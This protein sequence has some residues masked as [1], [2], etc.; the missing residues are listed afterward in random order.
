MNIQELKDKAVNVFKQYKYNEFLLNFYLFIRDDSYVDQKN[1][2]NSFRK[3]V[4]WSERAKTTE[5]FT[6][7]GTIYQDEFVNGILDGKLFKYI[8]HVDTDTW[9]FYIV[10]FMGDDLVINAQFNRK[11]DCDWND[12]DAYEFSSLEEFHDSLDLE[13]FLSDLNSNV[14]RVRREMINEFKAREKHL[15]EIKYEKKFT[16]R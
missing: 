12:I 9:K 4:F 8:F 14:N 15:T 7:D 1:F 3:K 5:N 16:F 6:I 10:L 11:A 2:I 13:N